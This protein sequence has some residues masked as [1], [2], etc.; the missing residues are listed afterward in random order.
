[1]D[2]TIGFW[3]SGFAKGVALLEPEQREK[4]FCACAKNCLGQGTLDY[5][6]QICRDAGGDISRFFQ[7]LGEVPGLHTEEL[8]S[9]SYRLCFEQC[10][11]SLHTQGYLN[12]PMLCECSRQSVLYALHTLFPGQEFQV[13]LTS[14][15]L[16]GA[17]ACSLSIR[18]RPEQTGKPDTN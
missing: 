1:M 2:Q 9:R 18:M 14:S 8:D 10:T 12:T 5:Y 17:Q 11:C 7:L 15:I 13:E 3:F 4:L 6:R 16:G